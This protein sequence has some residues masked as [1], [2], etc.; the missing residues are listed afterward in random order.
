MG[1]ESGIGL[2]GTITYDV[3]TSDEGEIFRGL[4]GILY[5]A[6]ALSAMKKSVFLFTHLGRDLADPVEK[7]AEGWHSLEQTGLHIF[8]GPGNHVQL[9]YPKE[10]ERRE[11]L[12]SAVSPLNPHRILQSMDRLQMLIAVLNSGFD[13]TLRDW[14]Q[15]VGAADCPI[16]LDIHSLVLSKELGVPRTYLANIPWEDWVKGVTYL[17]ANRAE[18]SCLIGHIGQ[19]ISGEEIKRFGEKAFHLG[20]E[21]VFIT[22]GK[23]GVWVLSPE[24]ACFILPSRI[25]NIEDTTGCGDVFCAVTAMHLAEGQ[26]PLSAAKTGVEFATKATTVKGVEETY[27]LL[28]RVIREIGDA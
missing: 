24:D 13:I 28:R 19:D 5:Q 25:D 26:D 23:D 17:Q 27:A 2:I 10:G 4:G 12:E 7:V 1:G 22:L 20:L 9:H 3:I 8:A 11:I 15:I 6:A 18:L 14:R 21:A 16:W